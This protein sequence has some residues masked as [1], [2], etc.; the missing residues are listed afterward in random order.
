VNRN[1]P[2]LLIRSLIFQFYFFASV[3]VASTTVVLCW[4]LG[5]RARFAVARTWAAS[6]LFAGRWICGLKYVVEGLENIP[7]TPSVILIKHSTV[8]E[9]YAQLVFFPIQTW[10]LKRELK[11]IPLFGWGLALLKPIAINRGAG[12]SAVTQVIS[13]GKQRLAEGIWVTVFPEGTRV[14]PG[15]TKK[16]GVSGAALAR[17]AGVRIVPVAHNAGDLWPRRG[18][19]KKPGLIRFVIGRPI[20]AGV[21]PP[22]ETNVLVQNW[23]EATMREISDGYRR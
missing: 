11:W 3:A 21:R 17:E 12:H 6:M 9:T 4:P 16:Y 8:F 14:A 22:K 10:V 5:H 1:E 18:I 7:D 20:D 15:K 19:I 2:L 23:I 13:Q